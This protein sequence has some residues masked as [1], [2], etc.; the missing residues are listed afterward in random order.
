[1]TFPF[2]NTY[3]RDMEGFWAEAQTA[4]VSAPHLIAFNRE[5]AEELQLDPDRLDGEL[6]GRKA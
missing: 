5:L 1:M 2:D 4:S 3:A 6:G